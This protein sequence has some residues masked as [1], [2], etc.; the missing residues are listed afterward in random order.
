M[1][2]PLALLTLL[3]SGLASGAAA[4]T[5]YGSVYSRFALGQRFDISTSQ[6]DAMGVTGVAIRA[7]LY[8]GL[9]NP[10]HG[11]DQTL[12]TLSASA[13]VR[14]VQATDATDATA[15]ATAGDLGLVQL[16]VP[17]VPG[18]I[19]L[20]LAYR[21]Y[22]RVDYRAAEEGEV[23]VD[24]A[25]PTRFRANLEGSGGLQT[26]SAGVGVRLGSSITV[27]ASGEALLGTV[28]YLQRTEFPDVGDAFFQTRESESTRLYGFTGTFGAAASAR[29]LFGEADA[30]TVAASFTLPATL[31]GSRSL[32]LGSSL[33][34]DTLATQD[35]GDVR[36][37]LIA[38]GG[39]AYR[40]GPRFL[41]SAD[42][43]YE[44]WQDF[45][46]DFRFGSYD[47]ASGESDLRSRLRVGAGLEWTPGGGE[48]NAGYFQRV[49]YRL[50]GYTETGLVAPEAQDVRTLAL[51]GGL[52]LPT[53]LAGSRVDLGFE[54]GTRGEA[55]G[56]L[57]RD[58]FWRGTLT[59]NFGERWFIRRRLG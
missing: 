38:R 40:S 15:E 3:A 49:A 14:G 24:G 8:N 50:G 23:I 46:S 28:E 52:S 32:T 2:R 25:D 37:P 33:D 6:A 18:R 39:I 36:L 43:L 17:L 51:T 44:P 41:A 54:V 47:A 1:L 59:F 21:P 4:Q 26:I 16:G 57:V 10:A 13:L 56:V 20:T 35:D 48:R 19:G 58:R 30:L 5:D 29:Q 27:G 55:S 34:R 7:G 9:S 22:S 31:R 53:R 45:E 11:A 42:A 12:T